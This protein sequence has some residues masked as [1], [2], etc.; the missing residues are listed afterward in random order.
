MV[1]LLSP[2]VTKEIAC[3]SCN[4]SHEQRFFRQRAFIADKKESDQHVIAYKWLNE[5]L[6]KLHPP[7]YFLFFCPHCYYTDTTDEF[8]KPHTTEYNPLVLRAFSKLGSDRLAFVEAL[9]SRVNYDD[10][11]FD[12]AMCLH[13]LALFIHGL[14][15]DDM[16]D[17]YK[18]ARI[19][20][21]IAWLYREQEGEAPDDAPEEKLSISK[22]MEEQKEDT[23]V[24]LM[25]CLGAVEG[26]MKQVD[27]SWCEFGA[28]SE[29]RSIELAQVL[30]PEHPY[31]YRGQV[32]ETN[33]AMEKFRDALEDL[34]GLCQRDVD[35]T[36]AR[37]NQEGAGGAGSSGA[38]EIRAFLTGYRQVWPGA[39]LNEREA[40]EQAIDLFQKAISADTRLSSHDTY[41]KMIFLVADL[42]IRCDNT[43]GALKMIGGIYKSAMDA[44]KRFNDQLRQSDMSETDRRRLQGRI[45]RVN[46]S[47]EVTGDFRHELLDR[48][49]EEEKETIDGVIARNE[50]A[51]IEV[52]DQA[53]VEAGVPRELLRRLKERGGPLVNY[54]PAKAARR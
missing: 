43:R 38:Q 25:R 53:L 30:G 9:G 2:F 12:S 3:P 27:G 34:R 14:A 8:S 21:R 28:L 51:P 10:I 37:S 36:A 44:R 23:M 11:D 16:R 5:R 17:N 54:E 47:M 32:N 26:A 41:F 24:G 18:L 42:M 29:R 45:N 33:A 50:G 15:P 31:D 20:M 46:S 48:L 22:L 6:Q 4:K 1:E 52:I 19:A 39:P 40:L 49:M 7:Y 13:A 35:D